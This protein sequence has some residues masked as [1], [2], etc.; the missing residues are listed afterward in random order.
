MISLPSMASSRCDITNIHFISNKNRKNNNKST[1][2]F[3]PF[4]IFG[5]E[6][7]EWKGTVLLLIVDLLR[8]IYVLFLPT[9]PL[10]YVL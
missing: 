7:N 9:F 10:M 8:Y 3:Q 1:S 6:E 5:N 4:W 2:Y